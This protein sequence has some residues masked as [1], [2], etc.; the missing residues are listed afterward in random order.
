MSAGQL[1]SPRGGGAGARR[2][3]AT[4]RLSRAR[5]TQP[6]TIAGFQRSRLLAAALAESAERGRPQ[7]SVAA[8]VARA[9]VSRKTFYEQFESADDCFRAVFEQSVADIAERLAPVYEQGEGDWSRRLRAALVEL[10]GFLEHEREA[11]AFLLGH[12]LEESAHNHPLRGVV[13]ERLHAIVEEG[14]SRAGSRREPPPLAAEMTVGGVLAVLHERMRRRSWD[15]SG[16]ANPLMWMIVLPYLG[17]AAAARELRR[18]APA[19]TPP[20]SSRPEEGPLAGL[21]M[22]VTYRTARVLA[23]IAEQPGCSNVEVCEAA[24]TA[25]QAQ[26]SRLLARLAGLGLVQNTGPGWQLGGANAWHLTV[27]GEQVEAA[28]R[29]ELA[30]HG[31]PRSTR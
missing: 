3:P 23:A 1:L 11:A 6:G 15:L 12:L 31:L 24:G 25:D 7:I 20:V 27:R 18:P 14:R 29:R 16:L 5:R 4:P 19:P 21:A 28:L 17:P 9:G 30:A 26:T 13:L 2:H 22:R 10:L 8:I